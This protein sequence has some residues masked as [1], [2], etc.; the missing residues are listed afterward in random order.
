MS[1]TKHTGWV[2]LYRDLSPDS[3]PNATFSSQVHP[4]QDQARRDQAHPSCQELLFLACV[5]V[6]WEE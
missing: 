3:E 4:S 6:E 2:N 5:P 1:K